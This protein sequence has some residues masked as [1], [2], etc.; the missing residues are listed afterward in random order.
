MF[1]ELMS[2]LND[3]FLFIV[4]ATGHYNCSR[5]TTLKPK[6]RITLGLETKLAPSS[7]HPCIS[8]ITKKKNKTKYVINTF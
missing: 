5:L 7:V 4:R 3:P 8:Q 6:K 1:I 2:Q